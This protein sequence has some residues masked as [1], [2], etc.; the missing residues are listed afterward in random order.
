M[1]SAMLPG[2][3]GREPDIGK[4]TLPPG[5]TFQVQLMNPT[6]FL[7]PGLLAWTDSDQLSLVQ[8]RE[9]AYHQLRPLL[10]TVTGVAKATVQGGLEAEYQ[11][12]VDPCARL[13]GARLLHAGGRGRR[14][15]RPRTRSM[16]WAAWRITTSF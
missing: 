5:T 10:T 16:P 3:V 14:S 2:R 9:I 6:V 12:M 15:C 4:A 8:L 13:E 7:E 1:V 11:V